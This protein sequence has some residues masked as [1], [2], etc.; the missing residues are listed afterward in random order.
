MMSAAVRTYANRFGVTA[1]KK[2]AVFA[3]NDSGWLTARDL[4]AAG[5]TVA[6]VLD[7][8]GDVPDSV[9]KNIDA[10]VITGAAIVEASGGR[11]LQGITVATS[12]GSKRIE[13]DALAVSGGWNPNF[14]LACH[15]G[16][17]PV[18]NETIA[19]F[20]PGAPPKG[21]TVVGAAAGAMTLGRCL[22]D[23]NRAGRMTAQELGFRPGVDQLAKADDETFAIQPYWHVAGSL[24]GAF[25]D[26]QND[27]T[28][29]DVSL[30]EREGFRSVEHLKRYT[31]LGMATDQGRPAHPVACVG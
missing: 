18:W 28:A 20:V 4:Q 3:N 29:A 24:K 9:R 19:A 13:C 1:G 26:I 23:G 5:V 14:A 10:H 2:V 22:S 7:T 8:R 21:M 25:V 15:L 16:G 31:T 11:R 27:V 17:D 12:T 30:A 6:A